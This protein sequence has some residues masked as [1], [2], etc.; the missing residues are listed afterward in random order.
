MAG[1]PASDGSG[2]TFLVTGANTGIGRATAAELASRGGRVYLACRSEARTHPVVEEIIAETGNEE[3][4]FVELDLASLRSVERCAREVLDRAGGLNVLINN[5][6]LAG[7]RGLTADGFEL[8]FGTNHLGHF[9]LTTALLERL[10]ANAPARVVT[11]ASEAHYRPRA[12][13]FDALREPTRSRTGFDEYGVSKLC[14]VLFTQELARRTAG[15]GLTAYAVHPG[16]I[17][18]DIWRSVPWP[19]RPLIKLRMRSPQEGARTTLHCATAAELADE[20]G[21]Y[22][23]ECRER[24]PSRVATPEL[25]R[26]LWERSTEWVAV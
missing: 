14:N 11:V 18:S 6:G 7:Q 13:D 23:E 24:R 4:E 2:S 25:A 26:E 15:T 5:A 3:V 20:S 19:L 10:T 22:Y 16:T 21:H 8:A 12:I 9:A 17:A 1:Q